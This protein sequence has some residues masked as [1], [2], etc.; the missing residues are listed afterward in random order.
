MLS[1]IAVLVSLLI[2]LAHIYFLYIELFAS[3]DTVG[4]FFNLPGKVIQNSIIQK[5]I[6]NLGLFS[7]FIGLV[8]ILTIIIVPSGTMKFMLIFLNLFVLLNGV[9]EGFVFSKRFFWYEALPGA[10]AMLLAIFM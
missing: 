5:F 8:I 4:K 1:T 10:I 6:Q 7:G 2:A 9:Y 3:Y